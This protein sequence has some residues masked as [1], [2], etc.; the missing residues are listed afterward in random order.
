MAPQPCCSWAGSDHTWPARRCALSFKHFRKPNSICDFADANLE[1]LLTSMKSILAC[2]VPLGPGYGH[3]I[4]ANMLQLLSSKA[5]HLWGIF[6]TADYSGVFIFPHQAL[7]LPVP[8]RTLMT[9]CSHQGRCIFLHSPRC[10]FSLT[11]QGNDG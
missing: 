7:H 3:H 11:G 5:C 4:S 6:G 8:S 10:C 1:H 9:V 2:W